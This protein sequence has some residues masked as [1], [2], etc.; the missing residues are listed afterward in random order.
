MNYM[1]L[2]AGGR[3][4]QD[5]DRMIRHIEKVIERE[6][7][8]VTIIEGDAKGA[9]RIA[10]NVARQHGLVVEVYPADWDKI[11][12]SAGFVRNKRMADRVAKHIENGGSGSVVLFPGGRGTDHMRRTA[13]EMGLPVYSPVR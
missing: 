6:G 2:I 5:V 7:R 10:G 1:M 13:I 3:D 8:N 11:G 12:K 9:D 4:Y